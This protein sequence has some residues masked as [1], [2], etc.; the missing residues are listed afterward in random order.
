VF[1]VSKDKKAI[2]NL[3]QVATMYIGSDSCSVKADYR[4]G[5][6]CQLGRYNSDQEARKAVEI[7]ADSIGTMEVCYMPDDDSVKARMNL[8]EQKY[9]H[10]T[11]KKT[12]G[13]GGS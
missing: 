2:I 11:G 4:S 8:E 1:I 6:G 5:N 7:V 10:I 3:E 12:K 13:H 9:H